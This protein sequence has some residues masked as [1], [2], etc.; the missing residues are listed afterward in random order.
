MTNEETKCV[1]G[2]NESLEV[3]IRHDEEMMVNNKRYEERWRKEE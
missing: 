1:G 3:L 2:G